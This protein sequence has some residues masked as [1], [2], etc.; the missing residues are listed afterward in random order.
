MSIKVKISQDKHQQIHIRAGLLLYGVPLLLH[1]ELRLVS[2]FTHLLIKLW[3]S[4]FG[5]AT[6]TTSVN[7]ISAVALNRTHNS[8]ATTSS[9][10]GRSANAAKYTRGLVW[11]LQTIII[12]K[13]RAVV[14]AS[15]VRAS[16]KCEP[17]RSGKIN[18][19]LNV[20]D[21]GVFFCESCARQRNN[22]KTRWHKTR[23]KKLQK[24]CK[25]LL[26]R[27]FLTTEFFWE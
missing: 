3:L 20:M 9:S 22:L 19:R 15:D 27:V 23:K 8:N 10:L 25:Y 24:T 26:C 5:P 1:A 11:W 14:H 2:S 6:T 7:E 12:W 17:V 21:L 18:L 4:A 13:I 16:E